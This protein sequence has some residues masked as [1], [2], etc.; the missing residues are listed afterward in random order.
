M[1]PHLEER[2]E[3]IASRWMAYSFATYPTHIQF[4]A[5]LSLGIEGELQQGGYINND[6]GSRELMKWTKHT[7]KAQGVVSQWQSEVPG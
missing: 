5:H 1:C 2:L 4:F 3:S 7:E 6:G